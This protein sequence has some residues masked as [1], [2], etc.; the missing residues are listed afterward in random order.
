MKTYWLLVAL[1]AGVII[2]VCATPEGRRMCFGGRKRCVRTSGMSQLADGEDD[3]DYLDDD[4][5]TVEEEDDREDELPNGAGR[6]WTPLRSRK[7]R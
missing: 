3:D 4:A 2:G 1:C 5:V 7:R 6:R